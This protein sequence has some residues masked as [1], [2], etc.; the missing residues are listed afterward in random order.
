MDF[1]RLTTILLLVVC[2]LAGCRHAPGEMRDG[3]YSA[4]FS[5]YDA[6][7]WKD[8]ITIYVSG[9]SIVTVEFNARNRSG[10]IRSWDLDYQRGRKVATGMSSAR[11]S[12]TYAEDLRSRQDPDRVLPL[13][14]AEQRHRVFQLLARA[15]IA[16]ARAGDKRVAFVDPPGTGTE[17]AHDI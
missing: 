17:S 6:E 7:G 11:Y 2:V 16:Q 4:E 14:Q 10:F 9:N 5:A 15:A 8:F 12:R 13:F 3:Y 1:T